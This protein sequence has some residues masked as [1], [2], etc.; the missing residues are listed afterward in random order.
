LTETTSIGVRLP[1]N[2]L[3]YINE[4]AK[5]ENVDRSV[6][7]RKLIDQGIAETRKEKAA[8]QYIQGKTSISGAAENAKITIPEMIQHLTTKGYTSQ[9]SLEDFKRGTQL[10]QTKLKHKTQT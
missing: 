9:Y 8:Q 2:V 6:I 10:L 1:K 3:N 5:K 7:I 4:E